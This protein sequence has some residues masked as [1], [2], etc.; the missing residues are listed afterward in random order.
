MKEGDRKVLEKV[1]ATK[2][3]FRAI[4]L[5]E[6]QQAKTSRQL[7]PARRVVEAELRL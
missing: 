5:W 1:V 2:T 3:E 7:L 4:G 6:E